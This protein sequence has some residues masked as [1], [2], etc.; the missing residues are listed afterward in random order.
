MYGKRRAVVN[1]MLRISREHD[2]ATGQG[3]D[4]APLGVGLAVR[5][6]VSGRCMSA[7]DSSC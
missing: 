5:G 7:K 1:Q 3:E 2:Q 6:G 4:V